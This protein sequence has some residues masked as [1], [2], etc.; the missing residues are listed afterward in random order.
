[1]NLS[2]SGSQDFFKE[3]PTHDHRI[4]FHDIISADN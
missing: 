1:M 3:N 2:K 4:I